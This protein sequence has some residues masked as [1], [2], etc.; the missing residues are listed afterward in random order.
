MKKFFTLLVVVAVFFYACEP[1]REI[2]EPH[3]GNQTDQP[4]SG[5]NEPDIPYTNYLYIKGEYEELYEV[6]MSVDYNY[7]GTGTGANFKTLILHGPTY[8]SGVTQVR[9]NY[10]VYEWD[11]ISR[12]WSDGTYY[13]D[14]NEGSGYYEYGVMVLYKG[15]AY[16]NEGK[17]K[18]S[19]K[20]SVR[21]FD[22]EI[23]DDRYGDIKGHFVG[24]AL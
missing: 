14:R 9:F 10:G 13:I 4:G 8:S 16:G 15:R 2:D 11:T 18:I 17:L 3:N 20:G 5:G 19:T 24:T 7:T 6:T 23:E 21:I 22:F 1:N 12:Y